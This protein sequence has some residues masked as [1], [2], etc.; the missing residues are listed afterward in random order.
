MIPS[1]SWSLKTLTGS[2]PAH[3]WQ[4]RFGRIRLYT[5]GAPPLL[6]VRAGG[7]IGPALLRG[8][9]RR[10]TTFGRRH[11]LGWD[12]VVDTVDVRLANPLNVFWLRRI[13]H[14][15]HLTRYIVI[16]PASGP[17]RMLV[18]LVE[19]LIRPDAIVNSMAEVERLLCLS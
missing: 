6:Y 18:P 7:Y 1:S 4:H 15:P 5:S 2:A 13:H 16:A 10:A 12:Y 19:L 14:L 8:T 3:D 11:P 17:V 9:L